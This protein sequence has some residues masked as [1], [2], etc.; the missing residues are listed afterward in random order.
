LGLTKCF[1]FLKEGAWVG[2]Y[3]S[4]GERTFVEVFLHD[5]AP[6]ARSGQVNHLCLEVEDLPA[7]V[8]ELRGKGIEVTEPKYGCDDT[9]QAWLKDPSGSLVELFQYTAK[10]AQFVGGDRE[11]DW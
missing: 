2:L 8:A 1:N 11:I 10:S 6:I 9:W 5:E 4:C 3:L 7:C